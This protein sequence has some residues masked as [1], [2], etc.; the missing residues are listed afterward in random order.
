M[1]QVDWTDVTELESTNE[2]AEELQKKVL[3]KVNEYLPKKT[4]KIASDDQPWMTDKI[5]K[6]SKKKRGSFG[7]RGGRRGGRF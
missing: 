1:I 4:I 7:R 5:K 6:F 3:D 2:K